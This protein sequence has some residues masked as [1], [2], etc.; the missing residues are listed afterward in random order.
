MKH[1]IAFAAA[2]LAVPALAQ[3]PA[4]TATDGGLPV[5][6]KTVTDRCVQGPAARRAEAQEFNPKMLGRDFSAQ[7]TP[8]QAAAGMKKP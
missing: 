3:A 8:Q 1:V 4:A 7:L 6:S 2:A 5:C